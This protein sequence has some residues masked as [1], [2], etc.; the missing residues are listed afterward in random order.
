MVHG[1]SPGTVGWRIHEARA[2]LRAAVDGVH[3]APEPASEVA[4]LRRLVPEPAN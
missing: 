4:P 3:A 2:R 1:C